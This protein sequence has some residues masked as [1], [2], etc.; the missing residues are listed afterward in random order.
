MLNDISF[1]IVTADIIKDV[2]MNIVT[3]FT[4]KNKKNDVE[5]I[6][7]GGI[8]T[9]NQEEEKAP[10]KIDLV[11]KSMIEQRSFYPLYPC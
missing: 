1:G 3:K 8:P 9:G 5:M 11:L 2:C 4:P 10:S 6:G 7:I